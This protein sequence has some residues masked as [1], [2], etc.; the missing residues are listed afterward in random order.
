[1]ATDPQT[2]ADLFANETLGA[3][4]NAV[5]FVLWRVVHRYVRE[6]DRALAAADLTHLQFTVLAMTA[7]MARSGE[8]VTQVTLARFGDIH[9]MQVSQVLKALEVKGLVARP[10]SIADTRAKCIEVTETGVG[11]L[12]QAMPLAI[13]VQE[14]LFGKA[15]APGGRLMIAL[16]QADARPSDE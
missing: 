4:E 2:L 10:R 16:A 1:M 12:R 8:P 3:P 13:S 6:I 15:G 7:W 5:G 14:R 11:A 9:P